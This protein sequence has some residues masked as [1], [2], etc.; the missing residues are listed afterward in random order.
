VQPL[1]A[2][3]AQNYSAGS[4]PSQKEIDTARAK[5]GWEKLSVSS[6]HVSFGKKGMSL[7]FN[8]V[9]QGYIADK[10]ATLLR[11]EGVRDVLINTGE[12]SAQGISPDGVAW[13][14]SLAD[15]S[16]VLELSNASIATSAPNGTFFDQDGTVGHILDPRT[17]M[18]GGKWPSLSVVDKSAARADGLSTAFCLMDREQ[19][20]AIQGA[21]E[22]L[23]GE[24]I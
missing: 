14:V 3:F 22:V 12:I 10:V 4:A 6:E 16:K 5:L 1:W 13:P 2:L 19:I 17:G 21:H 18:S 11:Q 20:D 8:G 9:A 23:Y 15:G 24:P 7:T